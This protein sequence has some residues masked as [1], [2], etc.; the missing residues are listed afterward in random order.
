MN[1]I[2]HYPLG[3]SHL[4]TLHTTILTLP[5]PS[6]ITYAKRSEASLTA[7]EGGGTVIHAVNALSFNTEETIFTRCE[8]IGMPSDELEARFW[9]KVGCG[10]DSE[11]W[12]WKASTRRGYGL[13]WNGERTVNAHRFAYLLDRGEEAEDFV[14]HD[15]DN[16]L[17]CNP[18]HLHDG[19]ASQNTNEWYSRQNA[20]EHFFG[21]SNPN[22]TL[23]EPEVKE[24]KHR[25]GDDT[26]AELA[27][28]F[29]VK[30]PAISHIANGVTWSDVEP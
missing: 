25:L 22:A 28:E 2:H 8:R 7:V 1:Q 23:T 29:G 10:S 6:G 27:E 14:L 17:C 9:K 24:I 26:Q 18:A 5:L 12:E 11:C 15:C 19:D 4:R 13:F 21:E 30:P 16:P 3:L 20:S